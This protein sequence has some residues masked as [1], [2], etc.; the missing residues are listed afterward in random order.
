MYRRAVATSRGVVAYGPFPTDWWKL[1][2]APVLWF[3]AFVLGGMAHVRL[4][5]DCER[6]ACVMR[7]TGWRRAPHLTRGARLIDAELSQKTR[8]KN[9]DWHARTSLE[10][11]DGARISLDRTDL[12]EA[13]AQV[14]QAKDLIA[15]RRPRFQYDS[16]DKRWLML[17]S[18]ALY[19]AGLALVVDTLWRRRALLLKVEGGLLLLREPG[20]WWRWL[21]P[22]S[23]P[24]S[25]VTDVAVRWHQV[26]APAQKTPALW[27]A[28]LDIVHSGRHTEPL[29][30]IP[31]DG[32]MAHYDAAAGLKALL[33]LPPGAPRE[34]CPEEALGSMPLQGVGMLFPT[35]WLGL[36][37]GL[38]GGMALYG[39]VQILIDPSALHRNVG[40]D[41]LV[42][43]AIGAVALA[44][45]L[46]GVVL[47]R[48]RER[49][50]HD[51]LFASR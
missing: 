5:I 42:A 33:E 28:T 20:R 34:R 2:L 7:S 15:G 3:L 48:R 4:Q 10:L 32:L 51:E 46:A 17:V 35:I 9:G 8:S 14:Q 36:C 23:F 18:A 12:K 21:P 13:E 49:Q 44:S 26:R 31:R 27:G 38:L 47:A 1:G 24:L 19:L 25:E 50:R 45:L 16:G 30:T 40:A 39:V 11:Q 29:T 37:C 22:R 41:A 6:E 43:A